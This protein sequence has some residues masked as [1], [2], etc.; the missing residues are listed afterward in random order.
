ME[1]KTRTLRRS[2]RHLIALPDNPAGVEMD[3]DVIP[4]LPY[5]S[6]TTTGVGPE[7]PTQPS[8]R[9]VYTRSGRV[10]RPPN[11]FIPDN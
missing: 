11:C 2:C 10:S 7:P 9:V 6:H 3:I 8:R 5:S 1:T 4:D